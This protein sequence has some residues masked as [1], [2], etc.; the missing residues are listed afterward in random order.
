MKVIKYAISLAI[1]VVILALAQVAL[2]DFSPRPVEGPMVAPQLQDPPIFAPSGDADTDGDGVPNWDANGS[3]IDNCPT[4]PNGY[5][6]VEDD[7]CDIDR[8]GEVSIMELAAGNQRDWNQDGVGDA[9]DDVDEDG[10]ADYLDICP[11]VSNPPD[12]NGIQDATVCSDIDGDGL[13]DRVDNCPD[14]YN[15]RQRDGD[16]DGIGDWCDNC[17]FVANPDQAD[18][19]EDGFG[20]AC[21]KD[22]DGDGISDS[23][24]NCPTVPNPDQANADDDLRGDACDVGLMESAE[25]EENAHELA[26]FGDNSCT[27]VAGAQGSA[28]Q[29]LSLLA[30]LAS[31]LVPLGLRKKLRNSA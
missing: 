27:L 8:D 23:E 21:I 25:A 22:A 4:V 18:A 2:A 5:C 16:E 3:R 19:D 24:D 28:G 17:R 9:C 12:E 15:P 6:N 10:I 13:S 20:D 11:S 29:I 26:M 1:P 14:L 31:I 7:D 30:C